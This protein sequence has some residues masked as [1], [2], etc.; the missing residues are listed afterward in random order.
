[1]RFRLKLFVG[2]HLFRPI[3]LLGGFCVKSQ[4]E[5]L[6]GA[7]R[8]TGGIDFLGYGNS[9]D[10]RR[11]RS[12]YAPTAH[13]SLEEDRHRDGRVHTCVCFHIAILAGV[14]GVICFLCV[15][16]FL[17]GR[18]YVRTLGLDGGKVGIT[19]RW[20]VVALSADEGKRG[21]DRPLP[22]GL[23]VWSS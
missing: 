5:F 10:S 13:C 23:G 3:H 17:F 1:M 8:L 4:L 15:M 7:I 19:A 6:F 20:A 12:F 9:D 22:S 11:G 2:A 18:M 21:Y 14:L 16:W